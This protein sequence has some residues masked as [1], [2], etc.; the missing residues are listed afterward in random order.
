MIYRTNKEENITGCRKARNTRV[1]QCTNN[2]NEDDSDCF[3][4]TPKREIA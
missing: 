1:Y 3:K 2:I 4:N